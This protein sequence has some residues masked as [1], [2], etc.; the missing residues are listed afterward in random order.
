[1][2]AGTPHSPLR[3]FASSIVLSVA[4][5]IFVYVAMGWQA[6][7][8]ALALIIIEITFSFDNAIVNARVLNTMNV[9]W[10]RMFMTIGI[11]VAVFGMRILF[12]IVIVMIGAGMSWSMVIDLAINDPVA[13]TAALDGSHAGIASFGG[14]F[15]LM[16]ALYFFFD[17]KRHTHWFTRIEEVMQKIGHWWLPPI[18]GIA[19]LATVVLLPFNHNSRDVIIAGGAGILSYLLI[20]GMSAFFT[21][22]H[23][24]G[25]GPDGGVVLKAGMAGFSA[26]MYLEVLDA[27]FSLD[28]VIGAFAVTQNVALIAIGLGVGAVWVRSLTL[29]MVHHQVLNAYRLLEHGAHYTIAVLS[30]VLLSSIFI[31]IP[32]VA[33]GALG[34]IIIAASVVASRKLVAK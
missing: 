5:L 12:P 26:F 23:E 14:M 33:I 11:V 16:L 30:L 10:Q 27:S 3:T 22:R 25:S 1:M 32:E 9:F 15:L 29:Y 20:A 4:A 18:I 8:A 31:D 34:V 13:Y 17:K 7:I 24:K 21:H 28:G 6:A 2:P 19:V